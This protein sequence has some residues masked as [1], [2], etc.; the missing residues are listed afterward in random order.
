MEEG[1][2]ENSG[3]LNYYVCKW[4]C[5]IHTYFISILGSFYFLMPSSKILNF[6][7]KESYP[8][9]KEVEFCQSLLV[10][11]GSGGKFAFTSFFLSN[12]KVCLLY[13]SRIR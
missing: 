8:M 7:R 9:K 6:L 5:I 12:R 10:L 13:I 11:P 2:S 3:Q 4:G 1:N